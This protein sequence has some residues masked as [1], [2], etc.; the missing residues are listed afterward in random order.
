MPKRHVF[1][2][3]ARFV[4]SVSVSRVLSVRRVLSAPMG[5]VSP[6]LNAPVCRRTHPCLPVNPWRK[7]VRGGTVSA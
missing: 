7:V 1:S 6:P 3:K 4:L 2:P 5:A